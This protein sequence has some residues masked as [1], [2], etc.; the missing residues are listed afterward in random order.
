MDRTPSRWVRALAVATALLVTAAPAWAQDID[1]LDEGVVMETP[2]EPGVEAGVWEIS[3]QVGYLNLDKI[4]VQSPN[5]VVD[6]E[7]PSDA[8]FAPMELRGELSFSPQLK[9]NRT[10]GNNFAVENSFGFA[11]GDFQ[12]SVGSDQTAWTLAGSVSTNT[13]TEQE[14]E[15]GSYFMWFHEHSLVYY[16]RGEGRIQPYLGLGIGTQH[17]AVDS[18]YIEGNAS[19]LAFSYGAGVRVVA[20]DLYS[21]RVEVRNY[22]SAIQY[23]VAEQFRPDQVNLTGD[24]I[25][26]FPVAELRELANLSDAERATA[27]A[28]WNQLELDPDQFSSQ[29]AVPY[30][31]ESLEEESYS[32]LWFSIGFVAAF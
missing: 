8:I 9:V 27:E 7:N 17:Y 28:L 24:G 22:H 5:V 10:F 6:V 16:P 25:V 11:I 26:G 19:S 21:F 12:Q 2:F 14:I 23:E 4:L 1:D 32:S 31:V 18:A 13:L 3:V 30:P 20:D 15:A 29:I